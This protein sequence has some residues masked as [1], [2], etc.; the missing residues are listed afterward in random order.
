MEGE[1][2]QKTTE[3]IISS[4]ILNKDSNIILCIVIWDNNHSS[5]T[6]STSDIQKT[7]L[8]SLTKFSWQGGNTLGM[9]D[10]HYGMEVRR[11]FLSMSHLM[12]FCE[13]TS[14]IDPKMICMMWCNWRNESIEIFFINTTTITITVHIISNSPFDL[15]VRG[16]NHKVI[17]RAHLQGL[18]GNRVPAS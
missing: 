2:W 9:E 7:I 12:T 15:N 8:N 6:T 5:S 10:S 11:V 18:S 16:S 1:I 17:A 14:V 13:K 3:F 4:R